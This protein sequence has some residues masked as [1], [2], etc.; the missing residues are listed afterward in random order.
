[1]NI[2]VKTGNYIVDEVATLNLSGNVIPESWYHTIVNDK[3]KVNCLAIHILADIVYWYRPKENSDEITLSVSFTKKFHDD[4]YL[5]RSYDQ[6]AEKFNISK[7][8][9][10]D[11]IVFLEGLG[12]IA[13]HFRTIQSVNG[14]LANVLFIEL[15]P[16]VLKALTYPTTDNGIYRNVDTSLPKYDGVSTNSDTPLSQNEET[17]TETTTK[18]T[19]N[20]TTTALEADKQTVVV[21]DIKKVFGDCGLSERDIMS[22]AMISGY[23]IG[24]C[25]KA[26]AVLDQQTNGINNVAGWLIK[27][28][29]EDYQPVRIKPAKRENF[30]HNFHEREYDMDELERKLLSRG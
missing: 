12:V 8:Q 18:T 1:M 30:F 2:D 14:P 15:V 9:A 6:L 25:K 28:I 10:R 3:G 11:A 13:R 20:I 5:Q 19:A 17:Y 4:N 22:I 27:A 16:E 23:D 29:R 21:D 7:K 26:K 24:R